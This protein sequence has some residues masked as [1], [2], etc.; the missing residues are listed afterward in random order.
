MREGYDPYY[1]KPKNG[2]QDIC[3]SYNALIMLVLALI[4]IYMFWQRRQHGSSMF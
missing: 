2:S 1:F 3:I 4:V